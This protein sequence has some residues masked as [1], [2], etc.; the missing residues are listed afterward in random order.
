MD[1]EHKRHR[2][3]LESNIAIFPFKFKL[4]R[5]VQELAENRG[6]AYLPDVTMANLPKIGFVAFLGK[7]PIA[8]GFLRRV[9]PNHGIFDTFLSNPY[10]GAQIRH[11][12][13]TKVW[14]ALMDEAKDLELV[15][16]LGFTKDEGMMRRAAESGFQVSDHAIVI[17]K[18]DDGNA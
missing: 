10:F 9:E 15:A 1:I 4:L 13:L 17:K 7:T 12:G 6:G 2:E 3:V 14:N 16:L 5:A 8:C 18:L 11:E